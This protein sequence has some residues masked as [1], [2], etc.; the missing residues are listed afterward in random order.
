M[1]T[2]NDYMTIFRPNGGIT[3]E[4]AA[5]ARIPYPLQGGW[6]KKYRGRHLSDRAIA[7][8]LIEKNKRLAAK[9]KGVTPVGV[10]TR[11]TNSSPVEDKFVRSDEFLESFEWRRIRM[12]ALKKYG[13]RCQCCGDSPSNGAIMNVDHIQPR[14][15]AP[16]LALDLGN[17]QVLCHACNHGKGNWDQSDWRK[18]TKP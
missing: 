5:I 7:L 2:L 16:R 1:M 15:L 10:A 9:T 4:E 8:M 6:R 13:N 12:S 18:P 3:A 11:E 17:L 14:K